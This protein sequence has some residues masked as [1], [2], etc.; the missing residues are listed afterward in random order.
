MFYYLSKTLPLFVYP[1][2]LACLLI[3]VALIV[4]WRSKRWATFVL[5]AALVVLWLGGNRVV[6]MSLVSSLEWRYTPPPTLPDL[7]VVVVLGGGIHAPAAPRSTVEVGNSGDRIIYAAHLYREGVA[8]KLIL[9]GGGVT[10]DGV[11]LYP[12]ARSMA[13]LLAMMGVPEG[14]MILETQ[15]RN[16][17]ENAVEVKKLLATIPGQ[18]IGLVTSAMH[19]PRSAAIFARQGI[20]VVPLPTDYTVTYADWEYYT[21]PSLAVQLYNLLPASGNLHQLSEALKEYIGIG[22]YWLRGWL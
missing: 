3:I 8:P 18:R 19:M 10:V 14:A 12:E 1:V 16:T 2:G 17:Y 13:A 9:A 6:M 7:D 21:Q 5:V 4:L 11:T 20:E 15:S 22:V